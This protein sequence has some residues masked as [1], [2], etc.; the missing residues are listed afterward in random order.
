MSTVADSLEL[1]KIY[2]DKYDCDIE[3]SVDHIN[4][5]DPS[6]SLIQSPPPSQSKASST[7]SPSPIKGYAS[8]SI[9]NTPIIEVDTSALDWESTRYRSNTLDLSGEQAIINIYKRRVTI[10]NEETLSKSVINLKAEALQ[11]EL[12]YDD[13]FE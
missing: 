2:E 11:A 5:L 7:S 3:E 6:I 13:N 12:W 8:D 9:T 1:D 4:D 10:T